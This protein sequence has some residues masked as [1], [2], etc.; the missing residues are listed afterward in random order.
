[1]PS[2]PSFAS[3]Y[4][5]R[6]GC[7][8]CGIVATPF[9][10]LDVT[11]GSG[12]SLAGAAG[13]PLSGYGGGSSQPYAPWR[14]DSDSNS[15][16]QSGSGAGVAGTAGGL[17]VSA[18]SHSS[19]TNVIIHKD[20]NVTAYIEKKFPVSSKGHIIVVLKCV[21]SLVLLS[22]SSHPFAFVLL[23]RSLFLRYNLE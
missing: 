12:S 4:A 21:F 2:A 16:V 6:P 5:H 15:S 9:S 11:N 23:H 19:T 1:M 14:R 13:R 3:P 20:A 8:L 7:P 22:S 17:P 10:R 18:T